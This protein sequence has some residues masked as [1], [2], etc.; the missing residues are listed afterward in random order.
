[1]MGSASR[2]SFIEKLKPF[3]DEETPVMIS[4]LLRKERSGYDILV[5]M[6]SNSFRVFRRRK[7]EIGDW[8]HSGFVHY[9][10]E[11][12][13]RNEL[14]QAGYNVIGF[15]SVDYGALVATIRI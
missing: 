3:L 6:F 9:F 13:T 10:T 14:S 2:I 4:F 15:N 12:E 1:M 7:T 11:E 8:F 5:K